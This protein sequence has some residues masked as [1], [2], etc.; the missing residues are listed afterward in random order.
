M[1][2][3]SL[4]RDPA[5]IKA[6]LVQ[7]P[8]SRVI[9]KAGL[10]I[11]VPTRYYDRGIATGGMNASI[12]CTVALVSDD[13]FYSVMRV[14][15]ILRVNPSSTSRKMIDNTDYTLLHFVPGSTVFLS[16]KTVKK[17][18]LVYY[19]FDEMFAK[20]NVPWFISYEDLGKIFTESV[21]YAGTAVASNRP[22]IELLAAHL[23]RV[24]D[25]KSQFIRHRLK[26]VGD[27]RSSS[28]LTF[29]GLNDVS[30]APTSTLYK[31]AGAYMDEGM[32]SA[33]N[34]PSQNIDTVEAILRA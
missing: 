28:D 9:T 33:L 27:L 15:A 8:D 32:I 14:P 20:G 13:G 12:M 29:I 6:L 10:T 11:H 19:I 23:A 5:K 26:S 7:L 17:D 16:N 2:V 21:Q 3:H 1:D 31:L 34:T 4:K 24:K 25:D 22:V 30:N 18:T